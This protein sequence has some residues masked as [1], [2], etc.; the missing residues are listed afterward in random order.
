MDAEIDRENE[1]QNLR[2]EQFNLHSNTMIHLIVDYA[3]GD[4]A[5]SEVMDALYR[6]LG[7]VN[8]QV[9]SVSDFNTVETGFVVGQLAL[10][11]KSDNLNV[12]LY[13]NC[14]PRRDRGSARKD[15]EGEELVYG[16]IKSNNRKIVAVNSGYSLSFVREELKELWRLNVQRGGSQFRS[17]DIFPPVVAAAAREEIKNLLKEPLDPK[18]HIPEVPEGVIGY[19]DSFGNIKTTYRQS[20]PLIQGLKA[21]D[22]VEA[23]IGSVTRTAVVATGSFNARKGELV[24]APG[25]SGYNDRFWELFQRDGSAR[26]EF[27]DPRAGDKVIIKPT[28][29]STS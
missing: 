19:I 5:I 8:R 15:N 16:V 26:K 27:R 28:G 20:S 22:L 14:A 11:P 2:M 9:T 23:T 3:Q 10:A 18:K 17:R 13:V 1:G 21:G 25:S 12:I 29:K 24:F 4:L 6:E 7:L